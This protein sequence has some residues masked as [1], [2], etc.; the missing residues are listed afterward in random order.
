ML[1][2]MRDWTPPEDWLKITSIDVHTAGQYRAIV[3]YTCPEA[4][5]GSTVELSRGDGRARATVSKAFDPP[6]V[7]QAHDRVPRVG[8]SYV[9]EFTTLE[10]GKIQ[11]EAGRAPLA[12]RALSVPGKQ[13]MDVRA[14]LLTLIE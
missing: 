11:L 10:L 13:V 4:D 14:V 5:L 7:G 2:K 6:L 9:K 1:E 3:Y 8:E 12:L